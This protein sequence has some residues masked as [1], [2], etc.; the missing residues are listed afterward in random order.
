MFAKGGR[1]V[2][3]VPLPQQRRP[4]V[5]RHAPPQPTLPFL[6]RGSGAVLQETDDGTPWLLASG[7]SHLSRGR[8]NLIKNLDRIRRQISVKR[9]RVS[10]GVS[11]SVV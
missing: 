2:F 4:R 1:G 6:L 7:G 9:V 3:Q 8:L 11:V 10:V 5:Q